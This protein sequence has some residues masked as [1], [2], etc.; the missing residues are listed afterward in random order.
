MRSIVLKLTIAAVLAATLSGC[1]MYVSPDSDH[2][3]TWHKTNA[4]APDEKPADT[5]NKAAA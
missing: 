1:I 3:Y 2:H 5:V 4:P